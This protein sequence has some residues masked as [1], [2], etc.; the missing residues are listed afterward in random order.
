MMFV[1]AILSFVTVAGS[2]IA[3]LRYLGITGV[4]C[5]FWRSSNIGQV[6]R[7]SNRLI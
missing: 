2:Q 6:Q 5:G 4:L 3:S 1:L 7:V